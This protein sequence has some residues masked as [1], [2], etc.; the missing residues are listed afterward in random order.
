LRAECPTGSGR[1]MTLFEI[2]RELASRLVSIF[3]KDE[4]G[5]RPV[6]GGARN[7]QESPHWRDYLLF[8]EYRHGDNGAGVG[9]SKSDGL[10]ARL[11][12]LLTE[13]RPEEA[14]AK[15]EADA[16]EIGGAGQLDERESVRVATP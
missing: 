9:A 12:G 13:L 14:S 6:F 4:R 2:A 16:L 5:R 1:M 11:A 3:R 15:S 10:V 7:F 8:Y